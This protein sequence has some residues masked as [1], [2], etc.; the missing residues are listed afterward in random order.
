MNPYQLARQE[1]VWE[2]P[3]KYNFARDVID[4]WAE[5][6][7]KLAIRWLDDDGTDISRTYADISDASRQACNVL[8]DAGIQRGDTVMLILGRQIAWWEVLTACLRMGLVVSPGITQLAARDLA[9]RINACGARAIVTDASCAK[10]IDELF[11]QCDSLTVRLQVDGVRDGWI[12]YNTAVNEAT[13]DFTTVDTASDEEVLCYFTS[14]T[15]GYPGMVMHSHSYAIGHQTTGRYWLDIKPDDLHWNI[16]DT[17]WA[18]AAW[19]SYFDPWQCGA[20]LFVHHSNSFNPQR[21]LELLSSYPVSTLCGTPTIYRMLVQHKAETYNYPALR[22]CVGVGAGEPLNPKI[23]EVWKQATGLVV[24]DG[25]GQTETTLLCGNFNGIEPRYGSMG[26]PSPGIELAVVDAEGQ[27]L[28]PD[29]EGDIG[30]FEVESALLEHPAV[31]ESAVVSSP[32]AE[33]GEV[34]KAFVVLTLQYSA[35]DK[36][37]Q[38]LKDHVKAVTAPY[39][40][41]R[42]I[43]FVDQLP[44]TVSGK[45]RRVEL[46][47]RER[48]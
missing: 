16:S 25:F 35:S 40:Y 28:P 48:A 6:P 33:R 10:K 4:R 43:E 30:S 18:K 31:A 23:I 37:A 3:K 11:D 44:K 7:D 15:T 21:V 47:E 17:G 14:G 26:K 38:A 22:H 13:T 39:K 1:F 5:D 36:L 20:A 27:P 46:R 9:Y 45:I 12:D 34:V 42:K 41:P 32:D 8:T 24:R 29:T 2:R 19:S